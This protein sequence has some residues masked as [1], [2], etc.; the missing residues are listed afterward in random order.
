MLEDVIYEAIAQHVACHYLDVTGDGRH[1]EALVVSDEFVNHNRLHRHRL[2][3]KAL[4]DKMAE[5]VHALSM[6]LYTIS[7]W[8]K[9]NG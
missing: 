1:F 3:Y 8:E 2:I 4:G 6:K 5:E 7:E 9:L